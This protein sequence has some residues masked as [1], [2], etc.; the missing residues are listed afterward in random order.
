MAKVLCFL[1][2]GFEEIEALTPIDV[3]RRAGVE[4]LTV[5]ITNSEYVKAAHNVVV[6]ADSIISNVV[7]EDAD[8]IL[9]PGGMPGARNLNNC[10]LLKTKILEFNDQGKYLAAICAAPLVFGGLGILNNKIAICYPGYEDTLQG[11]ILSSASVAVA[12]NVITAK[13][14]GAAMSFAL[15]L[16]RMLVDD[17]MAEDLANK[18]VVEVSK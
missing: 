12:D 3:L 4:L 16:V 10:E 9:L 7:F 11:A 8:M 17:A 2:E 15:Q 5:S 1:A 13:G 14:V 18:M 6:K